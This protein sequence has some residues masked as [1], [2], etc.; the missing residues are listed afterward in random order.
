ME[1]NVYTVPSMGATAAGQPSAGA[2]VASLATAYKRC[3]C[4]GACHQ[5]AQRR[6]SAN[7]QR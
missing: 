5:G 1:T 6:G 3:L 2:E 7:G 4:G